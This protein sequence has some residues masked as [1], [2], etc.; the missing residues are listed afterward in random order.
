MSV[1]EVDVQEV[2]V[3][4]EV[5]DLEAAKVPTLELEHTFRIM[6][7]RRL[8][9]QVGGLKVQQHSR[10]FL[11]LIAVI[12]LALGIVNYTT[13]SVN[14]AQAANGTSTSIAEI[15]LGLD[16]S[17]G[18]IVVV[19][20]L[21]TLAIYFAVA[22]AAIVR[23][24]LYWLLLALLCFFVLQFVCPASTCAAFTGWSIAIVGATIGILL[25]EFLW[26]LA[27]HKVYPVCVQ[28]SFCCLYDVGLWWSIRQLPHR[29]SQF[30]YRPSL[31]GFL[32]GSSYLHRLLRVPPRHFGY[33]GELD[34]EGR[35][36]GLGTWNDS[37]AQGETLFGVWEHG[38][39]LGPF[40]STEYASGY[41]CACVRIAYASC[42]GEPTIHDYYYS[43]PRSSKG[44]AW[45]VV[46]IETS[47]AGRFFN[48]LPALTPV[49]GPEHGKSALW[50]LDALLH[51]ENAAGAGGGGAN[52]STAADLV[53]SAARGGLHVSGYER[54]P[55][56]PTD[57]LTIRFVPPPDE[58]DEEKDEGQDEG[59]GEGQDEEA[60]R[61]AEHLQRETAAAS[62]ADS[63]GAATAPA[64]SGSL[65]RV[66]QHH[67]RKT[68]RDL[69]IRGG[70]LVVAET[71]E[72]GR[73]SALG[74]AAT[75]VRW[76]SE[77]E[78]HPEY[79]GGGTEE[80]EAAHG[81]AQE[82]ARGLSPD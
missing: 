78:Y 3:D 77:P 53:I 27:M 11:M 35:P 13:A 25:L 79:E 67:R 50:C 28:Q 20:V 17:I 14:S 62:G 71:Y 12:I 75:R 15:V 60:K 51:L 56:A 29:P 22:I 82:G 81:A 72:R 47:T 66:A 48:H 49:I 54:V 24:T 61:L 76:K 63:G 45:G 2:D 65:A 59:Q 33:D 37:A 32:P 64:P 30:A 16:L 52:A 73:T 6:V 74:R 7:K 10:A 42:R 44:L 18:Q 40:R 1:V 80:D 21:S 23:T 43:A 5:A 39:P 4:D 57:V 68:T 41:T 55:G 31:F 69:P 8:R 36:H 58:G 46:A 26:W 34:D 70:P 38:A 9:R 19:L